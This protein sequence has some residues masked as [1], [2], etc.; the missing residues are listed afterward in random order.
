MSLLSPEHLLI[1]VL[2]DISYR[3]DKITLQLGGVIIILQR[4][5]ITKC[6]DKGVTVRYLSLIEAIG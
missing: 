4:H 1:T 3:G 6:L 2:L 5:V